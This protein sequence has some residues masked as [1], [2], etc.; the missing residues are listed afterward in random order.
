MW[1]I[2]HVVTVTLWDICYHWSIGEGKGR[3]GKNIF[4]KDW[5]NCKGGREIA[6]Y[7]ND[8]IPIKLRHDLNDP[9]YECLW[10]TICPNW[11]PRSISKIALCC[12][13]L[14]PSLRSDEIDKFYDYMI[15]C[16]DQ[17]CV[18]SSSTAFIIVGD[19]NLKK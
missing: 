11:L 7:V 16:Y 1:V 3:L 18:E 19:F 5:R 13:Y 15:C 17:L 12:V 8:R 4:R 2:G 9:P 6:V 14:P 10:V